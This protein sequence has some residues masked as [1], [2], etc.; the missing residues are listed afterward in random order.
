MQPMLQRR[1][2]AAL[3]LLKAAALRRHSVER[4]GSIARRACNRLRHAVLQ[5]CAF[6]CAQVERESMAQALL[7]CRTEVSEQLAKKGCR[8]DHP[9]SRVALRERRLLLQGSQMPCNGVMLLVVRVG[10][11]GELGTRHASG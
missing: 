8:G 7:H 2:Y 1:A 3:S 11:R 5:F 9:Q 4:P 10:V 6:I